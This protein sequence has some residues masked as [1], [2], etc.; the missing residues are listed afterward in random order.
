MFFSRKK[1]PAIDR[2]QSLEAIPVLNADVTPA[3]NEAGNT[4]ITIRQ[5]RRQDFL[6]RFQPPV[7]ERT[8]KLDELGSFVFG[9]IDGTRTMLEIIEAFMA[10]YRTN[11]REATLSTVA[12]FKSLIKRG[13][14]SMVIK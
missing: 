13:A 3:R 5:K 6:G 14:I 2:E 4:V 11:R 10:R 12:F 9:Q 8:I 1:E 7:M